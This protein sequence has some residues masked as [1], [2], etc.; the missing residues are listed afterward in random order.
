M[1]KIQPKL[2]PTFFDFVTNTKYQV[3]NSSITVKEF[4]SKLNEYKIWLDKQR[5]TIKRSLLEKELSNFDTALNYAKAELEARQHPYFNNFSND[6]QMIAKY[7]DEIVNLLITYDSAKQLENDTKFVRN[8]KGNLFQ[9]EV[10]SKK[11]YLDTGKINISWNSYYQLLVYLFFNKKLIEK[12]DYSLLLTILESTLKDNQNITESNVGT[13]IYRSKDYI[14]I[15][16]NIEN[17]K[18]LGM[19]ENDFTQ[20]TQKLLKNK[21]FML[22]LEETCNE[23]IRNF[24]L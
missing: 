16:G 20:P 11:L 10:K 8:K 6:I 7:K 5:L 3:L 2:A 14:T 15:K 4:H 12:E 1:N 17:I 19:R 9:I 22:K 24:K 21:D 18:T 13:I 23:L